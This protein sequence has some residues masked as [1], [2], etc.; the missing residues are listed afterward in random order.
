MHTA[1]PPENALTDALA[2]Q[3][4]QDQADG[5]RRLFAASRVR[6]IPVVSNP[7]VQRGEVLLEGLCAAFAELGLHT[8][9]VDAGETSPKPAELSS[10]DLG[11]CVER[12][13]RDV[14]Y[15]A[16]RGLPM[17]YINAQGSA[18]Q[19]L[20]AVADAAPHA[21][22]ILLHAPYTELA[23]IVALRELRPVLLA[24]IDTQS[25][26]HAYAGMKWLAQRAGLM[27]YS[28]LMACSPQLRLSERIAQQIS[29]CGE[30][31]L[32]AVLRDWACMDPRMPVSAPITAEMRHMAR[33]LLQVAP[34]GA[35][36]RASVADAAPLRPSSGPRT[37]G[38]QLFSN[39][40]LL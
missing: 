27:V 37:L 1:V 38:A 22:V 21:D 5:L 20:E 31:F 35:A 36:L 17:R 40:A 29:S 14:T 34:P 19:F 4:P 16:A 7:Y 32:G 6:F 3:R 28:L 39:P 8:L 33:E 9:V 11:N 26:T 18:A 24:D 12:L 30:S 13:S 2:A 25:V 23:R 10:V 15:L